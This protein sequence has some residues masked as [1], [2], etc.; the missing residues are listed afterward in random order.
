[1]IPNVVDCGI[2]L[3]TEIAVVVF[4]E[5]NLVRGVPNAFPNFAADLCFKGGGVNVVSSR[6]IAVTERTAVVEVDAHRGLQRAGTTVRAFP[7]GM[8]RGQHCFDGHRLNFTHTHGVD[9]AKNH[10][11]NILGSDITMIFLV[12][13]NIVRRPHGV[14][15]PT[16]TFFVTGLQDFCPFVEVVSDEIVEVVLIALK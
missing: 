11:W 12:R 2:Q 1:M 5:H 16:W 13:F 15:Q 7:D 8:R 10:V 6:E 4:A 3:R 14:F 9:V